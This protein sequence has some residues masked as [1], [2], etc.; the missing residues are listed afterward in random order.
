MFCFGSQRLMS[1]RKKLDN[2]IYNEI[3]KI[4]Q[5]SKLSYIQ[6]NTQFKILHYHWFELLTDLRDKFE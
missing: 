1:V 3:I 2:E 5:L 6:D 4:K